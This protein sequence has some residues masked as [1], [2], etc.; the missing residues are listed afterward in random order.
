MVF[1]SHTEG[2]AMT[3]D[4]WRQW[5]TYVAGLAGAN[6]AGQTRSPRD[7]ASG[8]APFVDAAERYAAAAHRFMQGATGGS[9]PAATAAAGIFSDFLRE[10]FADFQMPWSAA[11]NTGNGASRAFSFDSPALGA[12]REQ[13]LRLQRMAGAWGRIEDAQ[14]RLQRLW[15]DALREAAT[16]FAARLATPPPTASAEEL[17]KLYDAWI[18]C[19]EDAYAR[20]AQSEAFCNALAEFVNASSEWR[21]ELQADIEHWAKLLDL[22]AR[23]EINT[24]ARRLKSVEDQLRAARTDLK[25]TANARATRKPPAAARIARKSPAAARTSRIPPAG[26]RTSRTPP[27]GARR[28]KR[29]RGKSKS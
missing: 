10:Q 8:F 28:T 12:T 16:A 5:Q 15:S 9:A 22:P 29:A 1:A 17:R 13:Q 24:L 4:P 26:A 14:R 25:P 27:A 2:S 19:A 6:S 18:D 20:S 23:G 21:R 3:N 11:F 7:G